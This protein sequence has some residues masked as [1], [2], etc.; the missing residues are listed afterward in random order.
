MRW[1]HEMLL[2]FAAIVIFVAIWAAAD[3]RALERRVTFTV[4]ALDPVLARHVLETYGQPDPGQ[5]DQDTGRGEVA[6]EAR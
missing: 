4:P 1:F 6:S 3:A 5:S 2:P